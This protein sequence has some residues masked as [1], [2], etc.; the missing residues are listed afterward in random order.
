MDTGKSSVLT[1]NVYELRMYGK[2]KG[3]FTLE[4]VMKTQKGVEV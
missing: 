2:G 4:Q 3:N 1:V